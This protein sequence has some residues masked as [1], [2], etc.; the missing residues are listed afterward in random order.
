MVVILAVTVI[1][2][3]IPHRI[4]RHTAVPVAAIILVAVLVQNVLVTP[5]RVVVERI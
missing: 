3:E 5:E 1:S 2:A 4:D